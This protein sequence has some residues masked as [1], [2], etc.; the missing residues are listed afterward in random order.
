MQ[1]FFGVWGRGRHFSRTTHL[2]ANFAATSAG[3]WY[4]SGWHEFA[5]DLLWRVQYKPGVTMR[6]GKVLM[7]LAMMIATSSHWAMLQSAAWTG[8]LAR[9]VCTGSFV[10]A[11]EKTFDGKH[12]CSLCKVIAAG[13]KSEKKQ[14]FAVQRQQLEFPPLNRDFILIA[15]SRFEI[16]L[17]INPIAASFSRRPPVPPP[18][19]SFV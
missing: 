11:L 5:I 16:V 10:D 4:N 8:M 2:P 19:A 12:P 13:K 17:S 9:N 3:H 18:R 14:E 6:L 1:S 7:L 15:P